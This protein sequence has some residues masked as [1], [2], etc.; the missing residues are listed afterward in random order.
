MS[1]YTPEEDRARQEELYKFLLGRGDKWT[2][3]EQTTDTIRLYP[4]YFRTTYHNS[5][6]R[7][8]LTRDIETINLS[9]RYEKVIISGTKGIKLATRDE[10]SRFVKAECREIFAKLKRVRQIIRKG[11]DDQQVDFEG[12]IRE[13]FLGGE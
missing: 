12:E 7:R 8:L 2:S 11:S 13:A 3:M 10:F 1:M 5:T 9:G 4:A 6:A